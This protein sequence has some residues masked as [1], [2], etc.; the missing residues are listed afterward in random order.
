[1]QQDRLVVLL[2]NEIVGRGRKSQ[3]LLARREHAL[4]PAA[5][6]YSIPMP[7]ILRIGPY[8]FFFYVNDRTEPIHVHV[9][10]ERFKAKFWVGPVRLA[11]NKGF[12]SAEIARVQRLV[13]Q[14]ELL[15]VEKWNEYFEA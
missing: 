13:S 5:L 4:R 14:H 2:E 15:I 7:T 11:D 12:R 3:R 6:C 8:R 9:E 10:R 1:M